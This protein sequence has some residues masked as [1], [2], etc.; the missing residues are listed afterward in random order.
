MNC[1]LPTNRKSKPERAIHFSQFIPCECSVF[2]SAIR[3]KTPLSSSVSRNWRHRREFEQFRTRAWVVQPKQIRQSRMKP[4]SHRPPLTGAA[5][6]SAAPCLHASWS[7]GPNV[8][9][10][11]FGRG[12]YRSDA[13]SKSAGTESGQSPVIEMSRILDGCFDWSGLRKSPNWLLSSRSVFRSYT[14]VSFK[15]IR[16]LSTLRS[17]W[18][19]FQ[20][21]FNG[22]DLP[23]RRFRGSNIELSGGRQV[24]SLG[25]LVIQRTRIPLELTRNAM[26]PRTGCGIESSPSYLNEYSIDFAVQQRSLVAN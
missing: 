8:G 3:S 14:K 22:N 17:I 12:S 16:I 11:G 9:Q 15:W 1:E 18:T 5:E 21:S 20:L 10:R 26:R 25:P 7:G 13:C 23:P 24:Q 19:R 4:R 2:A 6:P